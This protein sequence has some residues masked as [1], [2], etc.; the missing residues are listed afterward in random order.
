MSLDWGFF[1]LRNSF[2]GGF[3]GK[4]FYAC[5]QVNHV[6]LLEYECIFHSSVKN[7]NMNLMR[8]YFFPIWF[9]LS[10]FIH[11]NQYLHLNLNLFIWTYLTMNR[12]FIAIKLWPQCA[13]KAQIT[14]LSALLLS[15]VLDG[16]I[17]YIG[18]NLKRGY[19]IFVSL[20]DENTAGITSSY[21]A[22]Y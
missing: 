3:L 20:H 11:G 17:H 4:S 10:E 14:Q 1:S 19:F 21:A 12:N 7:I 18:Q 16:L 2:N 9:L 22:G 5:Y 13:H 8:Y 15:P 6:K